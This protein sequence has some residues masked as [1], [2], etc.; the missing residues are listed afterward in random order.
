[1]NCYGLQTHQVAYATLYTRGFSSFV[2]L[3]YC[4][5]CYRVERTSSRAGLIPA[6]DQRLFTAHAKAG[7]AACRG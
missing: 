5:D 7:L 6:L 1:M 2:T 3:H 4:S